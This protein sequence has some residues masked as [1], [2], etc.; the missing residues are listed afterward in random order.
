[1]PMVDDS[2]NSPEDLMQ[3]S[4]DLNMCGNEMTAFL[5]PSEW[6]SAVLV[7]ALLNLQGRQWQCSCQG[8][9]VSRF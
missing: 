6:F 4:D 2:S 9:R 5:L 3:S 8:A 7:S 1:M